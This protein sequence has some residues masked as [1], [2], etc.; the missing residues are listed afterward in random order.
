MGYLGEG[1]QGEGCD[2]GGVTKLLEVLKPSGRGVI[3][4]WGLAEVECSVTG[5]SIGAI[6][7]SET[8]RSSGV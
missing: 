2:S 7:K 6:P 3:L 8:I 4:M 5:Q 1:L